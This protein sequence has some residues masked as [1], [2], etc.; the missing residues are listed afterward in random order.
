MEKTDAHTDTAKP[1][2]FFDRDD[3]LTVSN[4]SY[5]WRIEDF[6]WMP[7]APETLAM[8]HKAGIPCFVATNQGGIARRLYDFSD[9]RAFNAHLQRE[10]EKVGGLITD[11]AFCPH[12]PVEGF[13]DLKKECSHR[14][15]EPGMLLWLADKWNIDIG[16][17]VM[18][19]D[20][21]RDL[22]AAEAAGCAGY[23]Y[24]HDKGDLYALAKEVM[25]KHFQ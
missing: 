24:E 9:T 5:V 25:E 3:T 16:A 8:F 18:I 7:G 2:V 1:A 20:A 22:D 14:K 15:P 23:L 19:G 13:G 11:I 17:S 21:S 10:A 4:N 6:A 12:H